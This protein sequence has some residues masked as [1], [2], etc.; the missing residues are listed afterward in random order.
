MWTKENNHWSSRRKNVHRSFHHLPRKL[1][2]TGYLSC[3]SIRFWLDWFWN[4]AIW[5]LL[6]QIVL[7]LCFAVEWWM[8]S[9][10][11]QG[12]MNILFFLYKHTRTH[13]RTKREEKK[14]SALIGRLYVIRL[15]ICKVW[16]ID[17]RCRKVQ[18]ESREAYL[19]DEYTHRSTY[20]FD[21]FI[22]FFCLWI[23]EMRTWLDK[24]IYISTGVYFNG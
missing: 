6:T 21:W 16:L 17:D 3:L 23:K 4:F 22:I 13:E 5:N 1:Q 2:Y 9:Y 7:S 14:C 18:E 24:M 20:S 19:N 11:V 8:C 15:S 10:S 12:W